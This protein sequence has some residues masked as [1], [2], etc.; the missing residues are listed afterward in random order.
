MALHVTT[1][2]GAPTGVPVSLGEHYID[3]TT[4]EHYISNGTESA[5][6][7]VKMLVVTGFV[8]INADGRIQVLNETTGT[9]LSLRGRNDPDGDPEIY[10][11]IY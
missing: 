7:W 1:G 6:N 8:R 4:G 2:S 5:D 9:W 11:S 10:A 3:T